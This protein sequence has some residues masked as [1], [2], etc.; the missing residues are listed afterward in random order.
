MSRSILSTI[1][2]STLALSG[3]AQ[4]DSFTYRG[5]LE[6]RGAPAEG[7]YD[8]RLTLFATSHDNFPVAQPIDVY[9]V[10]LSKGRFAVPLDL[11][12]LPSNLDS[13]WLEVAV[14]SATDGSYTSLT[15]RAEVALRGGICPAAWALDGNAGTNANTHFVG[16]TD[17][18]PLVLRS[19]TA[20]AQASLNPT[21]TL[22]VDVPGDGQI[23]AVRANS[24]LTTKMVTRF[25]NLGTGG[26]SVDIRGGENANHVGLNLNVGDT[27]LGRLFAQPSGLVALRSNASL[28]L[29]TG[30]N[31]TRMF[32]TADGNVG[33]G[34]TSPTA[35]FHVVRPQDTPAG[36]PVARFSSPLFTNA[37][38]SVET[39]GSNSASIQFSNGGSFQ[40]SIGSSG[41]DAGLRVES[42]QLIALTAG[43]G[44]SASRAILR[45]NNT[46]SLFRGSTAVPANRVIQVGDSASTG[47]GAYLSSGGAWTSASSRTFKHAF[48]PV[49]AQSVLDRLTAM[50]IA[51]W[52]YH[53]ADG[54]RHMGPVAEDFHAAFG[55]GDDEKY[56]G[57]VDADGVA[58]AA[59]QGL[60]AKLE[61]SNAA[62]RAELADIKQQHEHALASLRDALA[63]DTD[64]MRA[65]LASIKRTQDEELMQ[66]RA[67]LAL[68]RAEAAGGIVQAGGR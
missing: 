20:G 46:L 42:P 62:M 21:G 2:A 30:D 12:G 34:T 6:D 50:P 1:I 32:L 28:A 41:G 7:Q 63:S 31:L 52:S 33:V 39:E 27:L 55:L 66:M 48:E 22:N 24:A 56:I 58:L 61:A 4:A 3:L 44:A 17:Q 15:Q 65:E 16:T 68:L 67:E 25:E 35:R 60:N 51:T 38:V 9:D 19:G 11:P 57:T 13:G 29:R 5:Y 10:P 45:S 53:D 40:G 8:L 26:A 49:D 54:V 47:N 59:I 18:T 36:I 64:A 43:T 14:R 23:M 37:T